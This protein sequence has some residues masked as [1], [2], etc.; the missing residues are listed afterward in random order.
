LVKWK[1]P[2]V[3]ANVPLDSS[4]I[5][6]QIYRDPESL[7]PDSQKGLKQRNLPMTSPSQ[8][9]QHVGAAA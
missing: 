5:I 9:S 4:N 8:Q 2:P 7:W 3:P 6:E 1:S